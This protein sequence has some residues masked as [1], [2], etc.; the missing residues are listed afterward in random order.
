V[1]TLLILERRVGDSVIVINL[2]RV[3][4]FRT[5][6]R[7]WSC[8][9]L[10]LFASTN[11]ASAQVN[12]EPIRK[13]LDESGFGA[14]LRLSM[15]AYQ[16]NTQG[17]V[18][19]TS[20][21]FGGRTERHLLFLA[22]SADYA[23]LGGET[24]VKKSFVHLRH[25]YELASRLWWE[26]FVQLE[27]DRFRRIELRGLLGTGPRVAVISSEPV[28]LYYGTAYMIEYTR[29]NE[30]SDGGARTL[31]HRWNNYVALTYRPDPRIS[32][33]TITYYQ[34]RFDEPSDAHVLNVTGL[35]FKVT[36]L[37]QTRLDATTRYESVTPAGVKSSDLEL[38]SSLELKF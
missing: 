30:G 33:S 23:H 3:N 38:K 4:S 19:G 31:R 20:A 24:S 5:A 6:L 2:A 9:A 8:V 35:E 14:R 25:N 32:L 36:T 18:L 29:V 15:A 27:T 37:L 10:L 22:A 11:P 21:L 34:P 1:V 7:A 28:E 26:E 16:G 17:I 13:Q 12:V